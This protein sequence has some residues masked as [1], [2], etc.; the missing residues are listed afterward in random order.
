MVEA[1]RSI[2][3]LA[4]MMKDDLSQFVLGTMGEAQLAR[5]VADEARTR[6]RALVLDLWKQNTIREDVAV[7]LADLSPSY[8]LIVVPPPRKWV[9]RV[10]QALGVTEPVACPLPTKPLDPENNLPPPVPN[11]L[12]P[13]FFFST[14]ELFYIQNFLQAIIIA[15]SLRTLVPA[16]VSPPENFMYRIWT[17]LLASIN[18]EDIEQDTRLINLADELIRASTVTDIEAMK[19]LRAAVARTVRTS[20][21]VFLLLQRRL[22][23][24]FAERLARSPP[25]IKSNDTP[26]EMRT[27]RQE[28]LPNVTGQQLRTE[29]LEVKGF[30]DPVLTDA[31]QEVLGKLQGAVLWIGSIWADLFEPDDAVD[32][33]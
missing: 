1:I 14:P 5:S 23:S 11:M 2:L 33:P 12:P 6:E 31:I 19:Q 26:S 17:L 10:V 7:W 15:A 24:A 27:G 29:V 16:S 3:K 4:E 32:I 28:R 18:E 25:P 20:D 22:L 21:P 9:L 8:A 13:P 30:G